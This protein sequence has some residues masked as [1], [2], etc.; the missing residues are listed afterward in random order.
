M[1]Q[2]VHSGAATSVQAATKK[3]TRL[4]PSR[5]KALNARKCMDVPDGVVN[6]GKNANA[7]PVQPPH[8]ASSHTVCQSRPLSRKQGTASTS[9]QEKHNSQPFCSPDEPCSSVIGTGSVQGHELRNER[10]AIGSLALAPPVLITSG[11]IGCAAG[12]AVLFG[13]GFWKNAGGVDSAILAVRTAKLCVD[14][15]CEEII[16]SL[17][18]GTYSKCGETRQ[19]RIICIC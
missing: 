2:T 18:A 17:K 16:V 19:G 9:K 14:N 6:S 10:Q 13:A 1:S 5:R 15:F 11:L 4:N 7:G 12:A 3:K 8:A